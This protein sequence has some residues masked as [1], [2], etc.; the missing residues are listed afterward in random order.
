MPPKI[1]PILLDLDAYRQFIDEIASN[2]DV[3]TIN[4]YT[5]RVQRS[6]LKPL[7]GS[8][9]YLALIKDYN[10]STETFQ[11]SRFDALF[12]GIDY[13]YNNREISFDGI[14]PFLAWAG[15]AKMLETGNVNFTRSGAKDYINDD[16]QDVAG[17]SSQY[18]TAR[19]EAADYAAQVIRYLTSA[20]D[21]NGA[22]IYPEYQNDPDR[23]H[24]K[25]AFNFWIVGKTPIQQRS[26]S[27]S[28]VVS[29]D[30]GVPNNNLP[31]TLPHTFV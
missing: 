4:S 22:I 3:N 9:L 10:Q 17:L 27:G 20:R 23:I 7:I 1:D 28:A 11:T 2:I 29:L 14:A 31:Q 21:T 8:S 15:Y 19:S 6:G 30:P 12:N 5:L 13:L 24:N 26:T 18:R 16:S 25:T